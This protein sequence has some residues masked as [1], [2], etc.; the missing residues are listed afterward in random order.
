[1][2]AEWNQIEPVEPSSPPDS[3]PGM[4]AA[5]SGTGSL[6]FQRERRGPRR[7]ARAAWSAD[8]LSYGWASM[9]HSISQK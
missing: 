2:F 6:G 5:Q 1:M 3:P 4:Q 8:S 9:P 7:R